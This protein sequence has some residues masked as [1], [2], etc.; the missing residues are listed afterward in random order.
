MH[1]ILDTN[2]LLA[3]LI[4]DSRTRQLILTLPAKLLLPSFVFE[5]LEQHVAEVLSKSSLLPENLIQVLRILLSRIE[6]VPD[7]LLASYMPEARELARELDEKD[8]FLFACALAFPGSVI[9]SNDRKLKQQNRIQVLTTEEL[10]QR[11]GENQPL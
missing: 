4:R 9:W 6:I 7:R 8:A 3:A 2:I 5:E 11:P 1:I 10:L